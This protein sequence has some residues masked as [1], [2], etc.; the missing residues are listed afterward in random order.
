MGGLTFPRYTY[1]DDLLEATRRDGKTRVRVYR[2]TETVV[3]L[4][5]GS[6]ADCE[7]HLD[8]CR[9]DR[10]PVLRRRGGGCAVVLD[11][12]TVI[13]SVAAAGLPFGQHRRHLG[14][15]TDWLIT[16]LAEVGVNGLHRRGI[17]DLVIGEQKVGGACLQRARDALYYSASVLVSSEPAKVIR[18]LKHPPREPD[19]R[20]GR[21]HAAFMGTLAGLAPGFPR[22]GAAPDV[23]QLAAQLRRALKRPN[24]Q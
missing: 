12:G 24:L 14:A 5:A 23:E 15:L 21:P 18:Y 13:V 11:P 4:G 8:A 9:A 1:D 20:R 16:G 7:L 19:Y 2:L 17:C 3:V 6:R 10:V 22:A